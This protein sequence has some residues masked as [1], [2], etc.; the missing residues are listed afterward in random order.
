MKKCQNCDTSIADG[1]VYCPNCGW[2]TNLK[3]EKE[4]LNI[5]NE[6]LNSE[7]F[8]NNK[9]FIEAVSKIAQKINYHNKI[10]VSKIFAVISFVACFLFA[11]GTYLTYKSLGFYLLIPT[12]A[13]CLVFI[14]S[15]IY[16]IVNIKLEQI[17]FRIKNLEFNIKNDKENKSK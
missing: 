3:V 15:L 6:K 1:V 10:I 11:L 5:N 13:S 16:S 4:S 8:E 2:N 17:N 7:Y 12:I 14:V 9:I